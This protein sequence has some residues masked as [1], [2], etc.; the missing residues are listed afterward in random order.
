MS[1][2]PLHISN[3]DK[4]GGNE[5]KG[6]V[7]TRITN[8][9][10]CKDLPI[11]KDLPIKIH[12][13][14]P[15]I[16][17]LS[18]LEEQYSNNQSELLNPASLLDI[19][20]NLNTSDKSKT[21]DE[22]AQFDTSK[23]FD[24]VK[25][26]LPGDTADQT[27]LFDMAKQFIPEDP[28]IQEKLFNVAMQFTQL[29]QSD[30]S[31]FADVAKQFIPTDSTAQ[32]NMISMAKNFIPTDPNEQSELLDKANQFIS[33]NQSTT[34]QSE[35]S[36]GGI[37]DVLR[38]FLPS[39]MGILQPQAKPQYSPFAIQDLQLY[40]PIYPKFF[41]MTA[42]NSEKIALNHPYHV[43]DT[44]HV[45]DLANNEVVERPV[46]VKFSPLLDPFKYMIGKYDV[47]DARL[48]SMPSL[49]STDETVHPKLL[50]QNNASYVDCFFNY[51]SS[52]LL[53]KH[54]LVNGIDF[55]G[56]FL[57]LQKQFKV[58]VTDDMD[59]LRSS[60][61]FNEHAGE[62]FY[63]DDPEDPDND[64]NLRQIGGSRRN[65]QK[66]QIANGS[67]HNL[68]AFSVTDLD[69]ETLDNSD[70]INADGTDNQVEAV[71]ARSTKSSNI[72]GQDDN[73]SKS[74]NSDINYG[75]SDEDLGEKNS[76]DEWTTD[77][78]DEEESANNSEDD[79]SE[80]ETEVY[81]YIHNFPVQMICMEKCQ[82]TLDEL[83][84]KHEMDVDTCAS[85]LFQIIMTLLAYQKAF[86]FTHNDLHT[87]NV[88]YVKTDQPFLYYKFKGQVYKVPTYGKIFKLIDFGRSIYRF[89]DRA[90]CSDSFAPGGDA[91]TQYN[92]EPYMNENKPRLEPNYAF[93]LCRLGSSIYD[94][95]MDVDLEPKEFDE[96]QRTIGRWCSDDNGKNVLYKKNGE[97]RYPNF[98]LYKM[99]ARTVHA[100]SPEAQLEDAYFR[101]FLCSEDADL[102]A[103]LGIDIFDLDILPS[104]V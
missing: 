73:E 81:G 76:E 71:Y 34:A 94:F 63:I 70:K 99:I 56:S 8:A 91:A 88:M 68:S 20:Q 59:Y 39:D 78:E 47:Q 3:A 61:F 49:T 80:E 18:A 103:D 27:R 33:D 79:D 64:N 9:Q 77:D 41:E 10:R 55:Y 97:E 65:K 25:Q 87:N 92:F 86:K 42:K 60:D 84:V 95:I 46:F 101:Q 11:N 32:S 43:Q 37:M 1:I 21:T 35:N 29:S 45:L 102:G 6:N 22:N 89:Q 62:L 100:H 72:S 40:N 54:G 12:Y 58:C 44:N 30:Q 38:Q 75:S 57:G 19:F 13:S 50:S 83:F 96:L 90:F 24:M 53:H 28:S 17:D 31:K 15:P 82:G 14:K 2:T 16:I 4:V 26:F 74:S 48:R 36:M 85:A 67:A 98:K 5:C 66:L 104:Y 69:V 93:D 23:L 7:T 52:S 51:L